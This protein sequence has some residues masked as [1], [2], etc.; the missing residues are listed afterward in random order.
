[1]T[2]E[3][4]RQQFHFSPARNWMND[5]NG[6]V[7]HKGVYHLYFQHNP[8]AHE[9][10]NMSWGHATSSD[11]VR[12]TEQ[13][14]AIPQGT[15]H[16]VFS[17]SVVVDHE[18]TSRFGTA[19]D[20]P[21][22]AIYTSAFHDGR[23]S[24][25]LAFSTDDGSTWT[26]YAGNP[27]LDRGSNDFRDPHVF[28]YGSGDT[29]RWIL[30]AVEA[31]E[32][33]IVLYESGDLKDWTYLSSFGPANSLE[34]LWECPDLFELPVDGDPADTKWVLLVSVN[35]GGPA[36][37]SAMQYFVGEFDGTRFASSSDLAWVD[38]GH[39]FYGGIT[40][41]NAPDDRRIL[42]AWMSNWDYAGDVPTAP[43][44]GGMS[45]PRQLDLVTVDRSLCLRQQPVPELATLEMPADADEVPSSIR[46]V[47]E[48]GLAVTGPA[49][50]DVTFRAVDAAEFGIDVLKGRGDRTRIAYSDGCL[51]VDRTASGRTDFSP[52]FASVSSAPVEL[53]GGELHLQVYVDTASVEVFA[54]GGVVCITDQVFAFGGTG[55][56][57]FSSAG[58]TEVV[59]WEVS[60][61]QQ[62]REVEITEL[63]VR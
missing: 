26:K 62:S 21:L 57:L 23:Q 53:V 34:G 32:R 33:T 15:D 30:V 19:Q 59:D 13:P 58:T 1:M 27:V 7:F 4:H 54:Q 40:F 8:E 46:L 12:W 17:G 44:R 55:V 16:D 18:N 24:Q 20:P 29:A 42:L 11:L 47:G 60:R 35:S 14:L 25:S 48:R 38:W 31:V 39:D 6:L 52:R 28:R 22:V 61:L 51:T 37:G 36:G 50:I 49:V 3:P 5:P 10:S 63:Q 2:D 9:W 41:D 43:W 56:S 45:L